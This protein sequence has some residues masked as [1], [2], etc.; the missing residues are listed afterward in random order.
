MGEMDS[1]SFKSTPNPSESG[2]TLHRL[3]RE[4]RPQEGTERLSKAHESEVLS[5]TG[6]F[7]TGYMTSI[8]P[9]TTPAS[10]ATVH[11]RLIRKKELAKELS[12]SSRTIDNWV[13][14]KRIPVLRFSPRL[15]RYDL[16]KIQ[17]ALEK[18]EVTEVGRRLE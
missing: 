9:Q 15:L 16:R 12:V 17:A 4:K 8:S 3:M 18:Y 13:R 2:V 11:R 10:G 1:I 7:S 5:L 6:H 14:N